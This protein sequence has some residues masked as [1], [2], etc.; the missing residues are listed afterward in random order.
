MQRPT[1][2]VG[3][4]IQQLMESAFPFN[5][6]NLHPVFVALHGSKT[7]PEAESA[8]LL[9]LITTSCFRPVGTRTPFR[10]NTRPLIIKE[11]QQDLEAFQLDQE[12]ASN[13]D[14]GCEE[15]AQIGQFLDGWQFRK[16]LDLCSQLLICIVTWR[17][18]N[19]TTQLPEL[20][21]HYCCQQRAESCFSWWPL[22]SVHWNPYC[23]LPLLSRMEGPIDH[24]SVSLS[25]RI[26]GLQCIACGQGRIAVLFHL[27]IVNSSP[28]TLMN[29]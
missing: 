7:S 22:H 27:I 15:A 24:W 20:D 17:I 3:Y 9:T 18:E 25:L 5:H 13:D 6:S 12:A 28:F 4:R 23:Y 8:F 1:E 16:T 21:Q 29:R 2:F 14:N 10:Y 19:K 26:F 11:N